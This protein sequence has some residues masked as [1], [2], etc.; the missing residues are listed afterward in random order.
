M[1]PYL[2]AM[3]IRIGIGF[4]MNFI[5]KWYGIIS[6]GPGGNAICPLFL[7]VGFSSKSR[8]HIFMEIIDIL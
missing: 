8:Y 7:D 2:L 5:A 3:S 6:V 4:D 1:S